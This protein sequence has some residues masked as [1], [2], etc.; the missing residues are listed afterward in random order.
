MNDLI[1]RP[2]T[3]V[4]EPP[5]PSGPFAPTRPQKAAIVLSLIEPTEA[6]ILLKD[7]S[8]QTLLSFAR[9]VSELKPVPPKLIEQV[10]LEFLSELGERTEV[11]GG[12]EQ[13]REFLSQFMEGDE[14]DRIVGELKDKDVR[15]VWDRMAEVPVA[16]A[17][18]FLTL[19][20]PQT[21]AI[22]LAKL[23]T[24]KSA[25]ILEALDT[26][27][28]QNVVSR[29]SKA[30]RPLAG[31]V[32]DIEPVIDED[33][34]SVISRKSGAAK[35]AELI[36]NLMNNVTGSARDGFLKF[37]EENDASFAQDVQKEM[38][39][40]ADIVERVQPTAVAMIVKDVEEE[41]LMIALRYARDS[42][43]PSYEFFMGNLSKRLSERMTE[44]IDAMDEVKEKDG[45]AAQME[46]T[47]VIQ[48]KAK[49]GDIKLIEI[50]Q[51]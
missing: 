28:A 37:L 6:A 50:D 2:A 21:V 18:A 42:G 26:D 12:V 16:D 14:V 19:E 36:G 34:L 39:T 38:F 24:D 46:V 1:V 20:H 23:R 4:V 3:D 48:K 11:R 43:N 5:R 49:M 13:V 8:E 35:P 41:T 33:F 22:I 51:D 25:K 40:F 44:D 32:N 10:A 9:A 15:P 29:M 30:P 45:E 7:F 31:V 27:F 47:G 17:A